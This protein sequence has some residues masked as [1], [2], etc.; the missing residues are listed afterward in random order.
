MGVYD[1]NG[2]PLTFASTDKILVAALLDA[3]SDSNRFKAMKQLLDIGKKKLADPEAV[4]SD[5][6]FTYAS[7]G[8]VCALPVGSPAMYEQFQFD[9]L[10][11]KNA[12]TQSIPASTT[13]VMSLITG[14][15]YVDNVKEIITVKSSDVQ[16]GSGNYFSAGDTMTIEELMLAMMLPSSNTAAQAFG[17]ICGEKMLKAVADGTYTDSQCI[18]E[19]VSKM[20]T[21]AAYIGMAN[22]TFTS[23]S[24]LATTNKMTIKDMIQMIVEACTYNQILKVWNKKSYTI[25]VGGTNPR[26]VQLS[27]TVTDSA[28]EASY[29]ILGGKTGSLD[30]GATAA[31]LVMV[32]KA[33]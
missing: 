28:I 8:A 19:F 2:N 26:N 22:S 12:T 33:K 10:Y 20:N 11:S 6:E 13:K 9:L 32:A 25:S 1:I 30:S 16:A 29:Y 4:I 5:S 27:T 18:T 21:K 7:K 31:A 15:D 24:G 23:A 3:G 17:R 14:L